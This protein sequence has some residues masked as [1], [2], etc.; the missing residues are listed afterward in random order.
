[1]GAPP[2][3]EG[4]STCAQ[5]MV[6]LLLVCGLSW[7][8]VDGQAAQQVLMLPQPAGKVLAFLLQ[9]PQLRSW[10]MRSAC[11]IAG[12]WPPV[13]MEACTQPAIAVLM[14]NY[15][16]LLAAAQQSS[17]DRQDLGPLAPKLEQQAPTRNIAR[18]AACLL[19]A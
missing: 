11:C 2:P 9:L 8:H 10:P 12:G 14:H 18:P 17:C 15:G 7:G 1:M 3:C 16:H 4:C 19:R 13:R 5:G 6:G